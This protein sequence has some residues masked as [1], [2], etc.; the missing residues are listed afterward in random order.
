M[1]H[2]LEKNSVHAPK[3]QHAKLYNC[4]CNTGE[5]GGRTILHRSP[6]AGAKSP[7]TCK[8]RLPYTCQSVIMHGFKQ[9]MHTSCSHVIPRGYS[10]RALLSG[11]L[12]H[13]I[14]IQ[15]QSHAV[16]LQP[17][18]LGWR[19]RSYPHMPGLHQRRPSHRRM[20]RLRR[21]TLMPGFLPRR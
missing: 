5:H 3:A 11:M 17:R 20:R 1:I 15:L 6:T 19:R 2:S 14:F 16:S 21:H 10:T 8:A 7:M 13:A 4:T 12:H 9:W 18:P